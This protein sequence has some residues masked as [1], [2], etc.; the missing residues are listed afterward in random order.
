MIPLRAPSRTDKILEQLALGA[1]AT[2]IPVAKREA[3]QFSVNGREVDAKSVSKAVVVY[4][5]KLAKRA[6]PDVC[7]TPPK[8]RSGVSELWCAVKENAA[9]AGKIIAS[10][11]KQVSSWFQST[12]TGGKIVKIGKRVADRLN[13]IPLVR[14]ASQ[15]VVEDKALVRGRVQVDV[16]GP[17]LNASKLL[18]VTDPTRTAALRAG[19]IAALSLSAIPGTRQLILAPIAM[20]SG[21][22][23]QIARIG[24]IPLV[25]FSPGFIVMG[26]SATLAG[27]GS[28]GI[29]LVK[30]ETPLSMALGGTAAKLGAMT[31]LGML[32]G[33]GD[34]AKAACIASTFKRQDYE[35][36]REIAEPATEQKAFSAELA[37]RAQTP[38]AQKQRR[39]G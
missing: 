10:T 23:A 36:V 21:P 20:G 4:E 33:V 12:K 17:V 18:E 25:P 15:I 16:S 27:I 28:A 30:G 7:K 37:T 5:R 19:T 26:L 35:L 2:K 8:E 1:V 29:R 24:L 14:K 11:G 13:K 38:R 6:K 22:A 3:H 31:F 39:A 34:V 9:Q 32:P